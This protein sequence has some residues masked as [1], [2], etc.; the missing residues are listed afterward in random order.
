MKRTK[1]TLLSYSIST[2]TRTG[3]RL[4]AP[5]FQVTYLFSNAPIS[6]FVCIAGLRV[7]KRAVMRNRAKRLLRESMKKILPQLS[8][9]LDIALI[10]RSADW[11]NLAQTDV[12]KQLE[13][14]LFKAH[15]LHT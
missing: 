6:R 4:H 8:K 10:A 15:L 3:L 5:L 1:N 11:K 9:K 7:D 14:V 12:Q 13:E 2:L